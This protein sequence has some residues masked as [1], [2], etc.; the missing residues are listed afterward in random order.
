VNYLSQL[1]E[2]LDTDELQQIGSIHLTPTERSIFDQA[3]HQVS[4]GETLV[5]SDPETL[6]LTK[7]SYY[8][9]CSILLRKA[10]AA[11]VPSGGLD[12]LCFLMKRKFLVSN[13]IRELEWQELHEVISMTTDEQERFYFGVFHLLRSVQKIEIPMPYFA[14]YAKRLLATR[15]S[16]HPDDERAVRIYL[17]ERKFTKD[18]KQTKKLFS[19]SYLKRSFGKLE[20]HRSALSGSDNAFAHFNLHSAYF[21]Y[22]YRTYSSLDQ[23][24]NEL[25][26]LLRTVP[27]ELE[28]IFPW[29][30][31]ARMID[32][33]TI[34]VLRG[35]YERAYDFYKSHYDSTVEE[36]YSIRVPMDYF[37]SALYTGHHAEAE[38]LIRRI[39]EQDLK[40]PLENSATS[41]AAAM[42]LSC[43]YLDWG[44]FDEA[45]IYLGRAASWNQKGNYSPYN[46]AIIWT[47][48]TCYRFMIKE[49]DFTEQ[50]VVRNRQWLRRNEFDGL[51]SPAM[52]VNDLTKAYL[53]RCFDGIKI[54]PTLQQRRDDQFRTE[55]SGI[56]GKLLDKM[57]LLAESEAKR[58]S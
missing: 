43:T 14:K 7:N 28:S 45:G 21:N 33:G 26:G 41:V 15:T 32:E 39:H 1:L 6:G 5:E 3:A 46:E 4:L 29:V 34:Y 27:P 18:V 31:L 38:G 50:L 19:Q 48:E 57:R 49:W 11:L 9:N 42:W 37:M 13:G 56:I 54:D 17:E 44:H 47:L 51:D 25:A 12:L 52:T 58:R 22:Y 55:L 2:S 36:Y 40:R 20:T 53:G 10:Y 16:I 8:K 23:L 24:D 30:R 35:E